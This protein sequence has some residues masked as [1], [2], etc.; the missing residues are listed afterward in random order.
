MGGL[1]AVTIAI[2]P[3]DGVDTGVDTGGVGGNT[4]VG[5]GGGGLS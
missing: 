5:G 2:L 4:I 1:G 3:V